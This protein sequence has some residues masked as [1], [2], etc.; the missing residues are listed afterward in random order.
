MNPSVADLDGEVDKFLAQTISTYTDNPRFPV[1]D[2]FNQQ[3]YNGNQ[4]IC[5]V[6][7]NPAAAD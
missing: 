7:I 1:C 4:T 3:I 5:Y 6:N 2:A